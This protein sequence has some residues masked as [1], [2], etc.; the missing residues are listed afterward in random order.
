MRPTPTLVNLFTVATLIMAAPLALAAPTQLQVQINGLKA[1]GELPAD[2][3]FCAVTAGQPGPG[4]DRS[5]GVTWT[6]GPGGTKTYALVMTD[7]DVPK[8]VSLI[9]KPAPIPADLP[10]MTIY[11]WVLAD[12]PA[13]RTSLAPGEDSTGQTQGGKPVGPTP[14]GIRGS[15]TFKDFFAGNAAMAGPYGGYDG[16]CPP[17]NDL[18]RHHYHVRIYALDV[19]TLGLGPS[20]GGSDAEAAIKGHVL[21]TG[22][23]VGTYS[24]NPAVP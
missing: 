18:R 21:A 6:P 10:R 24:L 15:N 3:A 4:P 12:I 17:G 23:A 14:H 20:F 22:D 16:A 11:H 9:G 1:N 2:S 7:P 8:D 5:L 13:S 19:P